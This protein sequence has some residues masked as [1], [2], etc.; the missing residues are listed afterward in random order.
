MSLYRVN[1]RLSSRASSKSSPQR[2]A[3]SS[4][5]SKGYLF[6]LP[7]REI[8]HASSAEPVAAKR[9]KRVHRRCPGRRHPLSSKVSSFHTPVS[10]G[11]ETPVLS[12]P[13]LTPRLVFYALREPLESPSMSLM[14]LLLRGVSPV[15]GSVP[16]ARHRHPSARGPL[17][18]SRPPGPA[19]HRASP[20]RKEGS[21]PGIAGPSPHSAPWQGP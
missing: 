13:C 17:S 15:A 1:K 7:H 4:V 2:S 16:W 19:R 20:T 6:D 9:W 12:G 21:C 3:L 10:S 14:L 8:F 11:T 5:P 18:S